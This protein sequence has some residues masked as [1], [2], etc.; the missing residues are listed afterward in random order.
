MSRRPSPLLIELAKLV[1][2]AHRPELWLAR[3]RV[4]LYL[5]LLTTQAPRWYLLLS[6]SPSLS[7][8]ILLVC[9]YRLLFM[10]ESPLSCTYMLMR[11]RRWH[12][13]K[14]KRKPARSRRRGFVGG[15]GFCGCAAGSLWVGTCWRNRNLSFSSVEVEE[16]ELIKAIHPLELTEYRTGSSWERRLLAWRVFL[17]AMSVR[18]YVGRWTIKLNNDTCAVIEFAIVI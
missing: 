7:L 15:G 18:P 14:K 1:V 11:F 3:D 9:C 4:S 5:V 17:P 10:N 12:T 2:Q 6:P 16:D 8:Y 13:R